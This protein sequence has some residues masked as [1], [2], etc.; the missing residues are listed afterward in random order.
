MALMTRRPAA[1]ATSA[2]QPHPALGAQFHSP[3]AREAHNREYWGAAAK[4]NGYFGSSA[5][6]GRP[7]LQAT[8]NMYAAQMRGATAR[9]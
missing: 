5:R 8:G 9:Y 2:P 3:M 7:A 4:G 6:T 1:P